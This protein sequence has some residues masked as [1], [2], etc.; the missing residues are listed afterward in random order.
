MTPPSQQTP[1]NEFDLSPVKGE[2][3]P[4][5]T[6]YGEKGSGKTTVALGFPGKIAAI[7]FDRKTNLIKNLMFEGNDR[8]VVYDAVRYLDESAD[9]Y[10]ASSHKTV[11]YVKALLKEIKKHG[12]DYVLI[13]GIEILTR[14]VEQSMRYHFGWN[15]FEGIKN[16][17]AWKKRRLDLRTIHHLA[18]DAAKKGVIYTTYTTEK[19]L[20]Q[21]ATTI[22]LKH[23]PQYFDILL[24]ETDVVMR[25]YSEHDKKSGKKFFLRVDN[26]KL[27]QF[28]TGDLFETTGVKTEDL[29]KDPDKYR[30]KLQG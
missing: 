10:P 13:D 6:I 19:K 11:E 7:S 30:F 5:F 3:I 2:G 8:I 18:E 17:S 21:D 1:V 28:K 29:L 12:P 24:W 14:I 15:A 26:S 27:L 22:A 23:V 25:S 20:I 4:V 9:K 16:M